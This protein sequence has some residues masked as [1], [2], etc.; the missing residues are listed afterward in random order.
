MNCLHLRILCI[1]NMLGNAKPHLWQSQLSS[2]IST[3]V[4]R[5]RKGRGRRCP[6]WGG[7]CPGRSPSSVWTRRTILL[8]RNLLANHQVEINW[9]GNLG[10]FDLVL[11][12]LI[13]IINRICRLEHDASFSHLEFY[14]FSIGS[15]A[16]SSHNVFKP[17]IV[18]GSFYGKQKV[19][20]LTPLERKAIKDSLP[21]PSPLPSPPSQAK[22]TVKKNKKHVKGGTKL[23]KLA[24]GSSH[25]QKIK[26]IKLPKLNSRF[27]SMRSVDVRQLSETHFLFLDFISL[28]LYNVFFWFSRVIAK[29]ATT[30]TT[31]APASNKPAES[32]KAVAIAFSNLKPK[33]KIFVGAAFF[34]TGKK[35]TSMYKKS[36]PK[37][38]PRPAVVQEKSKEVLQQA[39]SETSKQQ[40]PRPVTSQ[41]QKQ[42]SE[43]RRISVFVYVWLHA[44]QFA[45]VCQPPAISD[46]VV[47]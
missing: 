21:S 2:F 25:V 1:T 29:P 6:Q 31:A 24:A 47:H 35:R 14:P 28:S 11:W 10:R 32:K 15:P 41:P 13:Y 18:S 40:L 3:P 37:P 7:D 26:S 30:K 36:A 23:R 12:G 22:E 33:P 16:K 42:P 27:V 45:N 44:A 46:G 19:I 38:S 20:Y 4:T 8:H 5:L 39:K 43:V 9:E 17:A 34:S